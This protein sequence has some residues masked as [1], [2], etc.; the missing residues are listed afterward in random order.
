MRNKKV[1]VLKFGPFWLNLSW[2]PKEIEEICQH[3]TGSS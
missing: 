3:S 1:K 2:K